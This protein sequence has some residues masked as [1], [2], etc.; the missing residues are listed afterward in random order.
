MAKNGTTLSIRL[1]DE[2]EPEKVERAVRSSIE[3]LG[4]IDKFVRKGVKVLVKPNLLMAKDV[5]KAVT[6][7]PEI[8]R[9]VLATLADAGAETVLADS[10]ALGAARS[11]ARKAGILDVAEKFG[12]EVMTLSEPCRADS[13]ET[14]TYKMLELSK[15]ALEAE[16]I[17]NLPKVK[18]HGA[19]TLTAGVKNLFGCVVG[20]AKTQWHLKAGR[21]AIAFAT[22]LVDIYAT[23]KPALTVAD[24]V[25]GMEG[26]GPGN[27]TPRKFGWIASSSDAVA[28]DRVAAEIMRIPVDLV[29][30]MEAARRAGV[31]ET[32]IDRIDIRGDSIEA[33]RAAGG[34]DKRPMEL[35]PKTMERGA[36]GELLRRLF[37]RRMTPEPVVDNSICTRCGTCVGACPPQVMSL[38]SIKKT[39]SGNYDTEVR[40]DRNG[41]IHCFCCQELC[42]EGAITIKTGSLARLLS[43]PVD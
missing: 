22:M 23:L 14:C 30:I 18:T 24:A 13:P 37:K 26:N 34:T 28:L 10:P 31:G 3:D 8:V 25:I 7:H 35:P 1:C 33:A 11:V 15:E 21:D 4:G 12:V 42:P 5:Q 40:I 19:M 41:C 36:M 43:R 32:E 39:K 17:V 20:R 16:V 2:Y 6:T 29:Y 38:A 27:G 9:A